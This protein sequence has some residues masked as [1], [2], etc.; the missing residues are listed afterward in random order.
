MV[1]VESNYRQLMELLATSNIP[2]TE[3]TNFVKKRPLPMDGTSESMLSQAAKRSNSKLSSITQAFLASHH[4]RDMVNNDKYSRTATRPIEKTLQRTV[5]VISQ[6]PSSNVEPSSEK[7]AKPH[8]ILIPLIRKAHGI[9]V[10]N[11][12]WRYLVDQ[13]FFFEEE[14][15]DTAKPTPSDHAA[16]VSA[17]RAKDIESLRK[18]LQMT[19]GQENKDTSAQEVSSGLLLTRCRS[20]FGDSLLHMACRWGHAEVV[21]FLLEQGMPI[22]L[23]DDSGRTPLHDACWTSVPQFTIVERL[24]SVAPEL[25]LIQD[26]RGHTPLQFIRPEHAPQWNSFLFRHRQLLRPLH[27]AFFHNPASNPSIVSSS[28]RC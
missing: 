18:L 9:A 19:R 28:S 25:L 21:Q 1:F 2:Q 15:C 6:S 7:C 3:R 8:D 16:A 27:E 17:V 4:Q 14:V 13:A 24:I 11:V 5:L 26:Q 20:K 12:S 10:K 22:R 23:I